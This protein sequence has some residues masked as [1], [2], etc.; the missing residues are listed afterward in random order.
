MQIMLV[1][2]AM[3]LKNNNQ[4]NCM[5]EYIKSNQTGFIYEI[6]GKY[7]HI[8]SKKLDYLKNDIVGKAKNCNLSYNK[9]GIKRI[10]TDIVNTNYCYI[11]KILI[12]K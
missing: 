12:S 9:T 8:S 2:Q 10:F 4:K 1:I 11:V 3:I 5:Y 7:P 6:K